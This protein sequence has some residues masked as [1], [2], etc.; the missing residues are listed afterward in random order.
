MDLLFNVPLLKYWLERLGAL[1]V[2]L[3]IASEVIVRS[4]DLSVTIPLVI[5]IV[6]AI[7]FKEKG[8]M[9][10]VQTNIDALIE[11]ISRK[12]VDPLVEPTK[13]LCL[14]CLHNI[15]RFHV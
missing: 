14:A 9:D 7:I 12:T 4:C 10:D 1:T 8:L 11:C 15:L 3:P 5:L 2:T 13:Q 6:S